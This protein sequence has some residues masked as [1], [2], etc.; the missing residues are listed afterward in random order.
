MHALS[1]PA[2]FCPSAQTTRTLSSNIESRIQKVDVKI[3][4]SRA[5]LVES[6]NTKVIDAQSSL[7][8]EIAKMRQT[9]DGQLAVIQGKKEK[10]EKT[11]ADSLTSLQKSLDDKVAAL[12]VDRKVEDV[13][14][15]ME[16]G[17]TK[18]EA[19][20]AKAAYPT[21][22]MW[23]GGCNHHGQRNGWYPYCHGVTEFNTAGA[24]LG[25]TGNNE[26]SQFMV[27]KTG[28]YRINWWGSGQRNWN[29]VG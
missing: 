26:N 21:K 17:L 1:I 2:T 10:A 27:K 8:T 15:N 12:D 16:T 23:S 14:K 5:N 4:T 13:L 3:G 22:L 24:Y 28:W 25:L 6:V 18:A 19:E 20:V 29:C 7:D 11:T 9:L